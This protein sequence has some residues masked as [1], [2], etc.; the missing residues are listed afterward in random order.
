MVRPEGHGFDPYMAMTTDA[1]QEGGPGNYFD[2]I[3]ESGEESGTKKTL[4]VEA[5][6]VGVVALG[7]AAKLGFDKLKRQKELKKK[8]IL[9]ESDSESTVCP[10]WDDEM[11]E[12]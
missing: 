2:K 4:L 5:I 11:D 10:D 8:Q 6:V 3:F 12:D 1:H 9:E 7:I